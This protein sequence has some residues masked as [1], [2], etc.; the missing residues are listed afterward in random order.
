METF[1]EYERE[2]LDVT[3]GIPSRLVGLD[4][5]SACARGRGSDVGATRDGVNRGR[6]VRRGPGARGAGDRGRLLPC[7]G[8]GACGRVRRARGGEERGGRRCGAQAG[9]GSGARREGGLRGR[10]AQLADMEL[11]LRGLDDAAVRREQQAKVRTYRSTLESIARDLERK[12]TQLAREKLLAGGA[13]APVTDAALSDTSKG[14]RERYDRAVGKMAAGVDTLEEARR[15]LAETE[16]VGMGITSELSRNRATLEGARSKLHEVHQ[17]SDLARS[18][19][20]SMDRRECRFK[21]LT[22]GI[23]IILIALVSVIIWAATRKPAKK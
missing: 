4:S 7:A 18:L 17:E 23:I 5:S 12:R 9:P 19:L 16:E 8:Q 3:K 15:T 10:G 2:F 14:Q 11:E 13:S 21:L 20:R 6:A 1:R 22:A